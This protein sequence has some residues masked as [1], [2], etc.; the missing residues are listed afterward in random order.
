[1][2]FKTLALCLT[3]L[4]IVFLGLPSFTTCFQNGGGLISCG[5]FGCVIGLVRVG[6]IIVIWVVH[7]LLEG[8]AR[9]LVGG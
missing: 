4:A 6:S 8:F 1:M 2:K 9:L 5:L 3:F 7:F